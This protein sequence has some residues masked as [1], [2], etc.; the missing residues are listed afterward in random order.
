MKHSKTLIPLLCGLVFL[1]SCSSEDKTTEPSIELISSA[2]FTLAPE[3]DVIEILFKTNVVWSA[4]GSPSWCTLSSAQGEAGAVAIKVSVAE[5]EDYDSRTAVIT[6]RAQSVE[7][8]VTIVQ[9]AKEKLVVALDKFEVPACGGNVLIEVSANV[10]VS[11]EIMGNASSWISR[12][13]TR[14]EVT[15]TLLFNVKANTSTQKR[16][17]K[18]VIKGGSLTKEVTII[19][20]KASHAGGST[21]DYDVEDGMWD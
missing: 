20:E 11:Y 4:I 6:L 8:T 9:K 2:L 5:N 18:I 17:G 12:E 10:D 3:A 19:Q 1:G 13:K 14:G 21:D 15:S 7:Q 16:E